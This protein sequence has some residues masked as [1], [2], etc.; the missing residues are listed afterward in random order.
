MA[1]KK[2]SWVFFIS[3]SWDFYEPAVDSVPAV[4]RSSKVTASQI[5]DFT[6]TSNVVT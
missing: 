3:I 4:D 6:G 1:L 2:D 5:N